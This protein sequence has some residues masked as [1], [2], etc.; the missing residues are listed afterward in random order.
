MM[1]LKITVLGSLFALL[2]APAHAADPLGSAIDTRVGIQKEAADSQGRIDSMAEET[3]A[4]LLEYQQVTAQTDELKVFD[5]Q[6][7]RQVQGQRT[8]LADFERQLA[9]V[10]ETQRGIVPFL[11]RML[12]TLE[13][14]VARDAPF[15]VEERKARLA[16]LRAMM[17]DPEVGLPERFRRIME[18]YQIETEYG[19]TI[20]AYS[21]KLE[22]DGKSRTV[23]FLRA[24]RVALVYRT[25]DGSETGFWDRESRA[26]KTLSREYGEPLMQ[27]LRVARKQAPPDLLRLPVAVAVAAPPSGAAPTLPM[28][29]DAPV[30]P[31]IAAQTSEAAPEGP[32]PNAGAA[33]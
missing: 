25:L 20:E 8:K 30:P 12:S 2:G 22:R 33:R 21:G 10:R 1:R 26:W 32:E 23:D 13:E 29:S 17:D 27:A 31:D 16:N 9:T 18:A 28:S 19:R 3:H 24:G 15:L 11:V 5:D 7:E 6:L 4:M 14:F